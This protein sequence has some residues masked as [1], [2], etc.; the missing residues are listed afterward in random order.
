MGYTTDFNGKIELDR[1]L[2][3]VQRMYLRDFSRTRRVKRNPQLAEQREDELRIAV[4]LP[5]GEDGCYFV[6]DT[7]NFGQNGGP[8]VVSHNCPPDGQPGLWCQWTPNESGTAIQ[9]D[10]GEKFYDYV[11]W[12]G[13]I[14]EHFLKPW[15]Y[16]AN[17]E[18]DWEGEESGDLG[19]IYV[20]DNVVEAV[21]S[22]ICN[23][24]PSWDR[25]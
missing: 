13:Y 23:S 7:A 18:I 4:G 20:K 16:V 6:G 10:Q 3:D 12:L 17:G 24:G 5:I 14:I 22:R 2:T 11:E 1:P 21:A 19:T 8:D 9:W 15:G 25:H